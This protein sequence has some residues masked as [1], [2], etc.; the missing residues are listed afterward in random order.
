M[1]VRAQKRSAANREVL[2]SFAI[3]PKNYQGFVSLFLTILDWFQSQFWQGFMQLAQ[4]RARGER[5]ILCK[6][7][8]GKSRKNFSFFF[9]F[10]ID[11]HF[12]LCYPMGVDKRKTQSPMNLDKWIPTRADDRPGKH[13][14]IWACQGWQQ[15]RTIGTKRK[16]KR[17]K[18]W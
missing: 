17:I 11:F 18:P 5:L 4:G 14:T 12:W 7:D 2:L 10:P 9:E 6:L 15:A 13:A 16:G 3:C 1:D 8:N